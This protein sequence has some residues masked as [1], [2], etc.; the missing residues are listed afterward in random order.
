MS[1]NVFRRRSSL[2]LTGIAGTLGLGALLGLSPMIALQAEGK[3]GNGGNAAVAGAFLVELPTGLGDELGAE[4]DPLMAFVT[5]FP[6]GTAIISVQNEAGWG[7]LHDLNSTQHGLWGFTGPRE[8]TTVYYRFGF[9]PDGTPN[10]V[11]K[12]IA[13]T[14]WDRGFN[15]GVG[16]VKGFTFP[17]GTDPLDDEEAIPVGYGDWYSVRRIT[18]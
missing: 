13:V 14:Q 18:H 1:L 11:Y 6:D 15:S 4:F 7:G 8:T 10:G 5:H 17:P 12:S 16:I 9:D 2:L 3:V